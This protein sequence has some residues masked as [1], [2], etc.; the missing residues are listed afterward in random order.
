MRR[1]T[2]FL[3]SLAD[4]FSLA[5]ACFLCSMRA[6]ICS[7]MR[8]V[9][10]RTAIVFPFLGSRGI[11]VFSVYIFFITS[12]AKFYFSSFLYCLVAICNICFSS[13][14]R[15]VTFLPSPSLIVSLLY[16]L[17]GCYTYLV[18]K[19]QSEKSPKIRLFGSR[20]A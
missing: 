20:N 9:V 7:S 10:L 11:S 19:K 6:A 14:S 2:S 4:F 5:A 18:S 16:S 8:S 17:L 15:Y 12:C 1:L 13:L 3:P